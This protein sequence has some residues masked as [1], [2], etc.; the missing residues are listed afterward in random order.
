MYDIWSSYEGDVATC[1]LTFSG[2]RL[3]VYAT[4]TPAEKLDVSVDAVVIPSLSA[5]ADAYWMLRGYAFWLSAD[6]VGVLLGAKASYRVADH[7]TVFGGLRYTSLIADSNGLDSGVEN[8]SQYW[9]LAIIDEI[10]AQ[11]TTLDVGVSLSF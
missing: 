1:D 7:W 9:N 4:C 10:T 6:G 3:G 5:E 8:G 11:Y 2:V